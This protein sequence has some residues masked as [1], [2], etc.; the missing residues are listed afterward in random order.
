MGAV[1]RRGE[2]VEPVFEGSSPEGDPFGGGFVEAAGI[3]LEEQ[4]DEDEARRENG[5]EDG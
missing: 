4:I 5:G 3:V 2:R 1:G